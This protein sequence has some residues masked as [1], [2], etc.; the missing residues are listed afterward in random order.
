MAELLASERERAILHAARTRFAY[1]GFSKVTM[2]EIAADVSM[3]K[4]SLYYYFP[5]KERLWESVLAQEKDQFLTEIEVVLTK[6]ISAS[7]KLRKYAQKRFELFR[8]LVNLSAVSLSGVGDVNKVFGNLFAELEQEEVK[9]VLR[10]LQEGR[11]SG[12]FTL[13]NPHQTAELIPHVL[14]GLRARAVRKLHDARP[15]EDVYESVKQEGKLLIEHL[16]QG[17]TR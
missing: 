7:E 8:E 14:Q 4:A 3:A 10:I 6:P 1:Y 11:R 16:L 5:T 13:S 9:L 12:E 2:D 15:A 17:M